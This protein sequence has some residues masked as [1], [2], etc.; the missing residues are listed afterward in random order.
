MKKKEDILPLEAIFG[1]ILGQ[2]MA[3]F[4]EKWQ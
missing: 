3:I 2:K 1:A 4:R